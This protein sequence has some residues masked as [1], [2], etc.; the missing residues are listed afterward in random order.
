LRKLITTIAI[1]ANGNH[2][3]GSAVDPLGTELRDQEKQ[4]CDA[5]HFWL[6]A[7]HST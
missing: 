5:H 7:L 4:K 6:I 2:A 1:I 3:A